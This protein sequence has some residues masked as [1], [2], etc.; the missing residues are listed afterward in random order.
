MSGDLSGALRR[1]CPALR[2]SADEQLPTWHGVP[3]DDLGDAQCPLG[4]IPGLLRPER[5]N[6]PVTATHGGACVPTSSR[7]GR[8]MAVFG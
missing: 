1:I 4:S 3:G 5:K 7:F 2:P 6:A 8:R